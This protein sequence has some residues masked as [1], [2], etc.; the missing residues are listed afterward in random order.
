MPPKTRIR[1]SDCLPLSKSSI[2]DFLHSYQFQIKQINNKNRGEIF[3]FHRLIRDPESIYFD[4]LREQI[5]Y[6]FKLWRRH[7]NNP[8][9]GFMLWLEKR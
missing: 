8:V 1:K 7:R 6:I 3:T 9:S 2:S 4:S 5:I